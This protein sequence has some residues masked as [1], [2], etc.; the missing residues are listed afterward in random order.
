MKALVY[1]GVETLTYRDMPDPVASSDHELIRIEAV[2][3]CGSDM[4]AYLGHDDRRPAPLILGHEAAG[5]IVGG[6]QDGKRVTINPLVTCN[7]CTACRSGRENLCAKRQ[8]ISMPPREGAFAQF[9]AMPVAN[10]VEVPADVPL[11]KA[12]LAEPLAVSWHGARL[13]V[14]A[15]HPDDPRRALIIGGGAIG[16]AA[17]LALRAMG[18]GEITIT[19]PNAKRR[20]FLR[21]HCGENIVETTDASF[22]I[23]IDAVGYATTREAASARV[24]PGGVIVHI[25]LGEDRGG[26]DV[27]RLTLQEI[28][29]IGTYTYTAQDFRDTAAA[30]FDG[31]LGPL[32]WCRHMPLGEGADAFAALRQGTVAEPKII[33]IPEH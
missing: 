19:E 8:I 6:A 11:S 7:S 23:V 30:I 25:G 9:V 4:H 27:R 3:I 29:F 20:G 17:A 16:L 24:A 2:G 31:R 1:D 33:L 32:D 15:L 21:D 26:I 14:A 10:L 13:A 22:S 5:I 28:T 18:V 12:A